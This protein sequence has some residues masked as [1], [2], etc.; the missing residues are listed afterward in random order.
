MRQRD[1]HDAVMKGNRMPVEMVRALLN[2][3]KLT[4]DSIGVWKFW[5]PKT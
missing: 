5:K 2:G 1:Y 4:P 3:E